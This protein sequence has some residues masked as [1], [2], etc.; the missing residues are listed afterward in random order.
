VLTQH[1]EEE[2]H[3]KTLVAAPSVTKLRGA[4]EISEDT[5]EFKVLVGVELE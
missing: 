2:V 3:M 5:N 4:L 1:D